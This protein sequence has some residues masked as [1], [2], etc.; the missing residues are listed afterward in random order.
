MDIDISNISFESITTYCNGYQYNE[1]SVVTVSYTLTK[2]N[3]ILTGTL[4][5]G[6][7]EYKE[8]AYNGLLAKVKEHVT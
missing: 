5:L 8:L 7:D 2:R 3:N 1:Q 6:F 4:T